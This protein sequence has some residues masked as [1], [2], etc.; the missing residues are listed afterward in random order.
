MIILG[1]ICC[2][3]GS[4][5]I[6]GKNL[7]R[8]LGRPLI[9]YTIDVARAS[10]YLTHLVVSTDSTE[11]ADIADAEGLRVPFL[12]PPELATD[13]ASKWDVFRHLVTEFESTNGEKI[14]FLVDMD[15]TV[16]LKVADDVDAAISVALAN[17]SLEV[18]ITA[19]EPER[20]PYFNMVT[21]AADRTVSIAIRSSSP[22]VRRQDA[23]KVY[24]LSPAAYVIQR[25]ALFARPHWAEAKCGIS[26]MPRER[27]LDIDTEFDFSLVELLA[28]RQK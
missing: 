21:M 26:L 25:D 23:P 2:R 5:G 17:R 19:Y 13:R 14:D 22:V 1:S 12:R 15:V 24:S 9:N 8:L 27:A 28:G 16:P 10:R 7:K 20:N 18:V 4:K 3:G 6:P 11:I